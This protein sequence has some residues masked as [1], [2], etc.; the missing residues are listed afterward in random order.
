MKSETPVVR[1]FFRVLSGVLFAASIFGIVMASWTVYDRPK[2]VTSYGFLVGQIW[3]AVLCG[4]ASI[5]GRVPNWFIN[6]E[7]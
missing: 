7:K 5:K 6:Q 4:Y 2:S 1:P 3:L